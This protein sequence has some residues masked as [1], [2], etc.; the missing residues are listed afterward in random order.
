MRWNFP[1][2]IKKWNYLLRYPV[3]MMIYCNQCGKHFDI[4]VTSKGSQKYRCPACG[5]VHAFDLEVFV[6]KAL[7]QR[8]KMLGKKRGGRGV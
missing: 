5:E 6:N 7:E 2:I 1:V 3:E 8:N 4:V